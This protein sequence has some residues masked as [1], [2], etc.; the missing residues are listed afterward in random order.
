MLIK[1][2]GKECLDVRGGG[3]NLIRCVTITREIT[4]LIYSV[5]ARART[6]V[7]VCLRLL[8]FC[9]VVVW[10][11]QTCRNLSGILWKVGWMIVH[12]DKISIPE[13]F[14]PVWFVLN[15]FE[16]GSNYFV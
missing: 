6:N 9:C 5:V 1:P 15:Y 2:A 12:V 3:G 14:L 4:H 13:R 10:L 7:F 11:R 16:R 8:S